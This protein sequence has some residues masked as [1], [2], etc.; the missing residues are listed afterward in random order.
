MRTSFFIAAV[1]LFATELSPCYAKGEGV[2]TEHLFGF[3][4]G[5]DPGEAGEREFEIESEVG[6]GKRR[7]SF[8]GSETVVQ[9][10]YSVTDDLRLAPGINFFS[11]RAQGFEDAPNRSMFAL[12]GASFELKYRPIKR[13]EGPFALSITIVPEWAMRDGSIGTRADGYNLKTVVAVDKELIENH[14][15]GALNVNFDTAGSLARETGLWDRESTFETSAA[16]AVRTFD[17]V[18][19]GGG[20]RYAR[21]YE[22]VA[23]NGFKGDAFFVGPSLYAKLND[24]AF[25]ALGW[26]IQVAGHAVGE[27]LRLDLTNFERHQI[28]FRFGYLF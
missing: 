14:V 24:H 26:N 12:S 15:Y 16:F 18:Y 25:V 11:V 3:T 6:A 20:L 7:G 13:E 4:E 5:T 10:K 21:A 9:T 17:R 23:L 28:A 22:G 27:A 1:G 19:L 2:D 8:A